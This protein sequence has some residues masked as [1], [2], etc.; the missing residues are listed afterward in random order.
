MHHHA[1][2]PGSDDL[3][4]LLPKSK[5]DVENA[6]AIVAC[7]YPA[8]TP[9]L[10]ELITWLQDINWPVAGVIAPFLAGLGPPIVAE[11]RYVLGTD[12]S[13]WK[14]WVLTNVVAMA[15]TEVVEA[16]REELTRLA[17]DPT[18]DEAVEE[19]D[20]EAREIL[21]RLGE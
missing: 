19:V 9:V 2:I 17:T 13:I 1:D 18:S 15:S 21:R 16:L 12:D 11:V 10:R 8:V 7:G 20:I 3:R 4:A 6:R 5:F 14:Y